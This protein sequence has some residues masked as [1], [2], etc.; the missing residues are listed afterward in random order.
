MA[1]SRSADEIELVD[2]T[3]E[4]LRERLYA[5][6]VY[7][8]ETARLASD[9]FFKT[10]NLTALREMALRR[11]AKTVDDQLVGAM[12]RQGIEGPWAA[13]ER[14]LV[15]VSGN[16]AAVSLVRA[17]RR[18]ADLMMD[19][20]WTVAHVERPNHPPNDP[21]SARRIADRI[22]GRRTARRR[23]DRPDGRRSAR[24]HPRVTPA[25]TTS[26]RSSWESPATPFGGSSPAARSVTPCCA[27]RRAPPCISSVSARPNPPAPNQSSLAS[28]RSRTGAAIWGP[29]CS[30]RW[31]ALSRPCSI[32][33]R[34]APTSA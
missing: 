11:A 26:P 3:P 5:G 15:L 25:A 29:W 17:G 32:A 20:P 1:R 12:R 34:A 31:R 16:D 33:T 14:I 6:K 10:E 24:H 13:G 8:P 9:N 21:R 28:G 23:D 19:A 30:W 22:Q 7:V 18:L 2:L 27:A 4:E